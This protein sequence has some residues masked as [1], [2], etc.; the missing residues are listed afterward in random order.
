MKILP[1][2]IE[3]DAIWAVGTP[4]VSGGNDPFNRTSFGGK[5]VGPGSDCS[6]FIV[7]LFRRH[8]IFAKGQDMTA[9][10][11]WNSFERTN[12]TVP[13]PL[14]AFYGTSERATH[15]MLV[16]DAT[17]EISGVEL[18]DLCIGAC[19]DTG[20]VTVRDIYYRDDFLGFASPRR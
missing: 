16:L 1:H 13:G 3:H 17:S 6:G 12:E 4:Y 18:F 19:G 14:C 9:D 8:D 5:M 2:T 7:W 11:M 15:V 20:V 10:G